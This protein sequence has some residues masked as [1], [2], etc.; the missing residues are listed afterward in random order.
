[1]TPV[2]PSQGF[3]QPIGVKSAIC[4]EVAAR[5]TLDQRR[6]A[7]QVVG[8]A[9]QKPEVD[10]VAKTIRHRHDLAGNATPR[11]PDGLALSTA[12]APCPEWTLVIVQSI[13]AYSKSA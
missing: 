9:G 13:M 6:R 11:A 2:A 4:E 7:A 10:Q 3:A 1:M 8:L 12:F 5:Q